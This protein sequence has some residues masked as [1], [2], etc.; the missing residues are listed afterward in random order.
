MEMTDVKKLVAAPLLVALLALLLPAAPAAAAAGVDLTYVRTIGGPGHAELYGW[1]MATARD[2]SVLVGDYWNFRVAQ[3]ATDGAHLRDLVTDATKGSGYGQHLAPYGIAVDPRNGDFYFGDV[4]GGKSVDKHAE[5]GGFILQFG[6][7]GVGPNRYQY[8][9]YVSV[10]STGRVFVSDQW[11]HTIAAV[12]PTGQE[13]FRFGGQGTATGRFRQP[14]GNAIGPGDELY[15]VDNYNARIQ[16]FDVNGNHLRSFG[17]VGPNPGQFGSNPDLRGIAVDHANGWVYVVDAGRAFVNKY[18]L[19]GDYLL[20][21][22][23]HGAGPGQFPGGGRDVTVDG[24]GNVWV[25]DMPG[26]RA[27]VFSPAGQFLFQVPV[28]GGEP[29]EG[30]FNQ[31]RGVSVDAQ[32]NV[33]VTDTHNWRVQKFAPNGSFSQ[34]WGIR[35]G[36][37]FSFNY[38][39]GISVDLRDGAFIVADTDN[40]KVKKYSNTGT[41][42]WTIGSFGAGAGQ[43]RNPHSLDVAPDGRI[44]VADTQNH[45]VQILSPGGEPIAA[46]GTQGGG[47]GQFR[48]PRSVVWDPDGTLWVSDS[49]R[50]DVQHL[51]ATGAFLGR[52]APSG[53][54]DDVLVRAADVEVDGTRVFVA[55]VDTHKVKVWTKQGEFLD[56]FGGSGTA[57]G[58]FRRPHGMQLTADGRLFVV[59]QA[60][61]RVQEFL[62]GDGSGGGGGGGEP[63]TSPPDGTVDVP[64]PR[65]V[66][67]SLPV[68]MRGGATDDRGVT[69]VRVAV[70]DRMS[71]DWLRTNGTWGAFQHHQASLASPGGTSTGWALSFT[72]ATGGSGQ[73]AMQVAAVDAA[74]NVDPTKPWVQFDATAGGGGGG[75]TPDTT[76][77]DGTVD[78]PALHQVFTSH[79]V[80]MRGDATDDRAVAEV[81]VAIRDRDTGQWFRANGTWG[82]FQ[83]HPAVLGSPGATST[84]WTFS[85]TPPA[86]GSGRYGMQAVA[87][88]AA[89]NVDP[90]KPWVRF[91]A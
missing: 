22:G 21:F 59:E 12:S 20:R 76:P 90:S 53:S 35:G 74:G 2:G 13:Q 91:D 10:A 15:V 36:G 29:P 45:R 51:S 19:Q 56:A 4:D 72:P 60:G 8:P 3:Y 75:G 30:G 70:R 65:Q 27:Q 38:Q 64:S 7:N 61:E 42:Q 78:V 9:S 28:S 47:D 17:S 11:N 25:G 43:F 63:D 49:L 86:S 80:V 33:F 73:Y 54:G 23:G 83:P 69:E 6:S 34:Q 50:G 52:I 39:R 48:F 58:S 62:V 85:W 31:P 87:V 32:G 16:V 79:P 67:T 68:E 41:H 40:H 26:F 82:A 77:P 71:G 89:G 57:P 66:F 81:T 37:A 46:F 44:A 24:E 5:D 14:R 55:D 18:T 84:T 1:G 88:D